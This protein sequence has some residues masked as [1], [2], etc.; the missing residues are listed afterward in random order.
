MYKLNNIQ[1]S[2]DI[3]QKKDEEKND[4]SHFRFKFLF[5][6]AFDFMNRIDDSSNKCFFSNSKQLQFEYEDQNMIWFILF[7]FWKKNCRVSSH[8]NNINAVIPIDKNYY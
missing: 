8:C 3:P 4:K 5:V 2:F 1:T 6:A 7:R